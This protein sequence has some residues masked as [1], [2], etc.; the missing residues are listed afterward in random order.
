MEEERNLKITLDKAKRWYNSGSS[1]L[2]A[3]ALEAFD[4][5][6]LKT[7][8]W[9]KIKTFKAACDVL[10]IDPA[11]LHITGTG[12]NDDLYRHI[13][14]IYKLDIIR[15]AL[16]KNWEPKLNEY[17]NIYPIIRIYNNYDCAKGAIKDNSLRFCGKVKVDGTSY[18]ILGGECE[19]RSYDGYDN[20]FSFLEV[21]FDK[22]LLDCK[23]RD[24][25][26]HMS[27]Y[28]AKEIFEACHS[29]RINYKSK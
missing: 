19:C 26:I 25:A 7:G 5:D 9:E 27:R 14:A 15:K 10:N 17:S 4:E 21:D 8:E 11:L 16:N 6:E 24:I 12:F 13:W 18:Y 23:S 29:H 28:F 22:G 20:T 1:E 2:K 3:L